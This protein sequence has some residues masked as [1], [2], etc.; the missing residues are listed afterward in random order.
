MEMN[1]MPQAA[2]MG[3]GSLQL[4][5][6]SAKS[7]APINVIATGYSSYMPVMTLVY[8]PVVNGPAAAPPNDY[9]NNDNDPNNH[10]LSF[11]PKT[12][13]IGKV[14]EVQLHA[15]NMSSL[16]LVVRVAA[17]VEGE[18]IAGTPAQDPPVAG[19]PTHTVVL[20]SGH[21]QRDLV[22]VQQEHYYVFYV[23]P[24]IT[25]TISINVDPLQVEFC[26]LFPSS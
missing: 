21:P 15:V 10:Y 17:G 23:P 19:A 7:T 8:Y 1:G 25:G 16:S 24:D 6:F 14:F 22:G 5:R 2:H 3:R 4:F 12:S 9:F 18:V 26:I 11:T 13:D 20:Q